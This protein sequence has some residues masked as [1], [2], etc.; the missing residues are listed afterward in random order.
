MLLSRRLNHAV[1]PALVN[2]GEPCAPLFEWQRCCLC[3]F[4][5]LVQ[6]AV[7]DTSPDNLSVNLSMNC[8]L[9][10]CFVDPFA[11]GQP[12]NYADGSANFNPIGQPWSYTFQTALPLT[13]N[14]DSQTGEYSAA[15]GAGGSF[16]MTGPG[17]L[18]FTGEITGGD[19]FQSQGG[20][21]FGVNLSF[22]GQWS[23]GVNGYARSPI[24]ILMSSGPK[25]H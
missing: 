16:L 22:A 10:A 14:Y 4:L 12:G 19:A 7:A 23:T 18:T 8:P 25:P 2:K 9:G 1:F 11:G 3:F 13:W 15:F 17:G 21:A 20:T 6:F 5:A 24:R